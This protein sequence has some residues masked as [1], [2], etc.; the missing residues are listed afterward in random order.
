MKFKET[1]IKGVYVIELET[2]N[3]E[4]GF[5]ARTFSEKELKKHKIDFRI[6]DVNRSFSSKKGTIRGMHFQIK[7]KAEGKI[8]FCLRGKIY[9]VAIDLRSRS[10]TYRK[11]VSVELSENNRRMLLVPAGFANGCQTLT[12]NCELQYFMS[13]FYSPEHAS[14]VRW[15]DPVFKI[16]WPLT[17][18]NISNKDKNWPLL[19]EVF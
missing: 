19:E 8:I 3:D 18:S 17:V 14:G 11:W 9:N 7:P 6:R 1:K 5:F 13:E 12:D 15:D 16:K 2:K 4:R 10:K